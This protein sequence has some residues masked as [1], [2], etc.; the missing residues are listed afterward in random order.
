MSHHA[1]GK[2]NASIRF[3]LNKITSQ[4]IADCVSKTCNSSTGCVASKPN[5]SI[6]NISM[7]VLV[8]GG[9]DFDDQNLVDTTLNRLHNESPIQYLIHGA[10]KGADQAAGDWA[11]VNN[12]HEIKCPSDWRRYGRAAGP[13]RNKSMLDNHRPD[14]LVAFPGG[15]GT[16]HMIELARKAGLKIIHVKE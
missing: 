16:A 8:T 15:K 5:L 6:K 2:L 10:A 7:K 14:L 3:F 13:I 4:P 11:R 1:Q 12:V 9:R